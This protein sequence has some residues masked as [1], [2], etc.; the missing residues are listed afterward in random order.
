MRRMRWREAAS[1]R[2]CVCLPAH[3]SVCPFAHVLV[4]HPCIHSFVHPSIICPSVHLP[5]VYPSLYP[6]ICLSIHPPPH[7]SNHP[8]ICLSIHPSICPSTHPP[9]YPPTPLSNHPSIHATI[10]RPSTRQ[11]W[12]G[13]LRPDPRHS[14]K[15]YV[16]NQTAPAPRK[17]A[18]YQSKKT[19]TGG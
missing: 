15:D 9:I 8:P 5:S 11:L 18:L 2:T 1:R 4:I 7:L 14:R 13:R 16:E 12:R 19:G 3:P 10:I 6:S 17:A